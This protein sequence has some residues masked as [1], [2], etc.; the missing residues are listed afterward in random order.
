MVDLVDCLCV[1]RINISITHKVICILH[2]CLLF[3]GK[4]GQFRKKVR[5]LWNKGWSTKDKMQQ[6]TNWKIIK[7]CSAHHSQKPAL[8][9]GD[10]NHA[11]ADCDGG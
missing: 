11:G 5:I 9:G 2:G 8:L 1:S 7:N 6:R 3:T 10:C 4:S